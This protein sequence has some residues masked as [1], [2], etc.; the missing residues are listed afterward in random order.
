MARKPKG[1]HRA[2]LIRNGLPQF[3]Y[4]NKVTELY[5]QKPMAELL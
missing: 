4:Y 2:C 5:M 3:N 1:S